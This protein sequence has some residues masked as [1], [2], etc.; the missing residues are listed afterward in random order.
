MWINRFSLYHPKYE[1]TDDC[2]ADHNSPYANLCK[3]EFDHSSTAIFANFRLVLTIKIV[4]KVNPEGGIADFK[5]Y[6]EFEEL[7][8][9]SEDR[10][11]GSML[12]AAPRFM[13]K[14]LGLSSLIKG[15]GGGEVVLGAVV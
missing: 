13:V 4:C 11:S 1:C 6:L 14:L 7:F 15:K 3:H 2:V 10:P 9:L 5:G 12:P 8:D